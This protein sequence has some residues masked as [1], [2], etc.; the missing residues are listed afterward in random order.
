MVL[1]FTKVYADYIGD[2]SNQNDCDCY[3][4]ICLRVFVLLL[5][6]FFFQFTNQGF[7]TRMVYL[8]YISCLGYTILVGNPRNIKLS[9]FVC[10]FFLKINVS[11]F[12]HSRM[13]IVAYV[14]SRCLCC[15]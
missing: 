5:M 13:R 14:Y 1:A 8:Y 2:I 6:L 9:V 10:L 3:T 4:L 11:H 7:P 15:S 12:F